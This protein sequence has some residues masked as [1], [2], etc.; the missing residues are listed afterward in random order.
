MYV[1]KSKLLVTLATATL[2]IAPMAYL[3]A[4][5]AGQESEVA[6][7]EPAGNTYKYAYLEQNCEDASRNLEEKKTHI[8]NTANEKADTVNE[9]LENYLAESNATIEHN[10]K[11]TTD[12]WEYINTEAALESEI[13]AEENIRTYEIKMLEKQVEILEEAEEQKAEIDSQISTLKACGISSQNEVSF[14]P[15]EL[16]EIQIILDESKTKD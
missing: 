12:N 7:E 13:K 4:I 6:S 8:Q 15:A 1:S 2:L 16:A 9:E 3:L 10:R 11:I 5:D 14:S